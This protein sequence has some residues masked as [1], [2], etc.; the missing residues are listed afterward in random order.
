V[1]LAELAFKTDFN[2]QNLSVF[3]VLSAPPSF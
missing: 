2:R 3:R 1:R